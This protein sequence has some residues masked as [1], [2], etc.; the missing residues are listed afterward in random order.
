M[1][2]AQRNGSEPLCQDIFDV[3]SMSR[4]NGKTVQKFNAQ[5]AKM[6]LLAYRRTVAFPLA[7]PASFGNLR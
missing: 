2:N 4:K 1:R 6:R 3:D 7:F 5:Y